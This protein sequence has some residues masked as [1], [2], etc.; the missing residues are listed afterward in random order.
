MKVPPKLAA[1][2]RKKLQSAGFQDLE[3]TDP[4]APLSNRGNLHD[5][6]DDFEALGERMESGAAYAAWAQDVLHQL[7]GHSPEARLRRR[8]WASWAS[9]ESMRTT[10]ADMG[11]GFHLVR[12]TVHSIEGKYK[13]CTEKEPRTMA[14]VRRLVRKVDPR[15]LARLAAALVVQIQRARTA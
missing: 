11:L 4:D 3:G 6:A 7:N 14:D 12:R 15:L 13:R 2:W 9:G 5:A 8:I 1:A 10:A